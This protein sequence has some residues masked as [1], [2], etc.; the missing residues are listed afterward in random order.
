MFFLSY[1]TLTK[2]SFCETTSQNYLDFPNSNIK[3]RYFILSFSFSW[4]TK[5]KMFKILA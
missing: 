4:P 2:F 5:M 1:I 3:L